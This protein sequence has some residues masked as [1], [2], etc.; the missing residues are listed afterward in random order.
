METKGVGRSW[1]EKFASLVMGNLKLNTKFVKFIRCHRRSK[2]VVF[3][4]IMIPYQ[5]IVD[6]PDPDSW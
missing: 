5:F 2:K 6:T 1:P 4:Q 3:L